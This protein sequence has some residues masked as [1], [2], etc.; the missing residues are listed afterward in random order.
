M[1]KELLG[2]SSIFKILV[3]FFVLGGSLSAQ[4]LPTPLVLNAPL[5]SEIVDKKP[6]RFSIQL[7]AGQTAQI[8]IEQARMDVSLT[9]YNPAGE[10]LLNWGLPIGRVGS[11]EILIVADETGAYQ[12]EVYPGN[13]HSKT[14]KFIIKVNEIRRTTDKDRVKN[15]AAMESSLLMREINE[16]RQT[17]NA[18]VNRKAVEMWKRVIELSKIREDKAAEIHATHSMGYLLTQTGDVQGSLDVNLQAGEGWKLLKNERL[19]LISANRIGYI[20]LETG[21]YEKA[22]ARF[23]EGA[24]IARKIN[25]GVHEAN[26][27]RNI[28]EAYFL[29]G[30]P[31]TAKIYFEQA[32][33]LYSEL[34]IPKKEAVILNDL[35]QIYMAFGDYQ[36]G[37]EYLQKALNVQEKEGY[38]IKTIPF[39]MSLGNAYLKTGETEKAGG[40]FVQANSLANEMGSR[41]HLVESFYHLANIENDR[42]NLDEAINNLENGLEII[43]KTRAEIRNK[44]LRTT[45]FSTVQNFYELYT[46]LLIKRSRRDKNAADVALAFEMSERS[47]ARSL[48]DLLE[49]AKVNLR[50]GVDRQ[51]LEK[52]RDLTDE[53]NAKYQAIESLADRKSK[54][55]EIDEINREILDLEFGLEKLNLEIRRENP[56]YANLT[57]SRTLSAKEIQNLLDEQSVLLEYKLGTKRSFLWIVSKDSIEV[58]DLPNRDLIEQKADSFYNLIVA[59]KKDEPAKVNNLSK[60]LGKILLAPLADKIGGKRLV[61]VADGILQYSPFS[62]LESP[63]SVESATQLLV[64]TNEIVVLPS[65]SVLAQLRENQPITAR[66]NKTIAIFADPVFDTQDS[67]IAK[68]SKSELQNVALA[69]TLR[70]FKFGETLPRLL[71]SREEARVISKFVD[72]KNASVRLGFDANL[73]NIENADLSDYQILHFATHG[74][75]N[76][77]RPELSGLVFSLYDKK[78]E[79]QDGFLSLNDIYNLD[80]SSDLVVLSACQTALGK[81]VR[82]EGLIGISR[83]FLYAGSNRIVASL[84]KVDDSATAE[85]MKL[86]YKNHLENKMSAS[87]ALRQA[88]IEMKK[89]PRYK[90]PYYWSAFTL[91]GE[92]K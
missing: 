49:E 2:I 86:F 81:D 76:T 80:I 92:W 69:K 33:P 54:E 3:L 9:S 51:L 58:F 24:K 7:L 31:E 14:G 21:E 13:P 50:H 16:I 44:A 90:S 89:I 34:K 46:D 41:T 66:N 53:I 78:G 88:K 39:Y 91:L 64:E 59:N 38:R 74:L 27:I 70:D 32:L 72:D 79:S 52:K 11:E 26:S 30:Q 6:K 28:G 71:A 73:E 8:E 48:N 22:I 15:D 35:G 40:F 62:A 67:R 5:E 87:A 42:G 20:W 57:K 17:E 83:G 63:K 82:G 45:Y 55:E 56:R 65:A 37:I 43:E 18:Q 29:M 19:E 25:S 85:F 4:T 47:R 1:K 61:I 36:K 12:I 75:L 23:K 77:S 60:D 68:N 10:E 84:W